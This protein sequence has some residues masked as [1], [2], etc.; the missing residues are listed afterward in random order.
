MK[1]GIYERISNQKPP[2][3]RGNRVSEVKSQ[4]R[5]ESTTKR[6]QKSACWPSK[7]RKVTTKRRIEGMQHI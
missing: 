2:S 7:T 4:S 3:Q 5:R 6:E 1:Q